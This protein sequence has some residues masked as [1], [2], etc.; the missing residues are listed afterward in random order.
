MI[1]NVSPPQAA[2]RVVFLID[3]SESLREFIAGGTKSKAESIATAINSLLNQ[4][5]T[6]PNLELAIA[7][8]RNDGSNGADVGCRWSGPL[9]G[10][11]FVSSWHLAEN[12]V[13]IE[14]RVRKLPVPNTSGMLEETIRFP[15]WYVPKLG[16][17]IF[18]VIGYGYCQ[19]L[20]LSGVTSRTPWVKPPLVISFVGD[21]MSQQVELAVERVLNLD[22]PAGPPVLMHVHL[23]GIGS[24][25]PVLYPSTDRHMTTDPQKV[26]YRWSSTLPDYML[27]KLRQAHVS[28]V[29]G[30]R[31]MI[32]NATVADLIRMLSLVK[33]YAA[34]LPVRA[35]FAGDAAR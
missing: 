34:T 1:S 27:A 12:P 13:M 5:T 26:L 28:V 32:Y 33:A 35:D 22:S 21:W 7:G 14:T 11:R 9:E 30:A 16:G 6:V 20:V 4:L 25:R 17:G 8:Y 29:P 3:E 31:T 19:H 18:P 15:I 2:G 24:G 23:G 10:L